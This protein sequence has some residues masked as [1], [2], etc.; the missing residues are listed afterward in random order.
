MASLFLKSQGLSGLPVA[1]VRIDAGAAKLQAL[2]NCKVSNLVAT[3]G[4]VS[5]D[6]LAGSLPFP[7][8]TVA[9]TWG[10]SQRQSDALNWIPFTE[11]FNREMLQVAGLQAGE[12][13]LRIDGHAIGQWPAS[14]FAAGINLVRTMKDE[15]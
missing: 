8:D 9:R 13:T 12:Y 6:Y 3:T 5:F 11:D 4:K 10:N 2:V 14:A 15:A 1:D 7:V